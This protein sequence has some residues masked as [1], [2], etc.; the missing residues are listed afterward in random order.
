MQNT[1]AVLQGQG[2][3]VFPERKNVPGFYAGNT[4]LDHSLCMVAPFGSKRKEGKGHCA[5]PFKGYLYTFTL[6]Q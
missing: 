3:V 6:G 5:V 2:Q 4:S 1:G